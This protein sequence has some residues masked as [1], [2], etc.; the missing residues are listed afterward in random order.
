[1]CGVWAM[2]FLCH[3]LHCSFK[4]TSYRCI[5]F[6]LGPASWLW[7]YLRRSGMGGFF[8][9][10]SGGIDSS[11]TAAIVGSMCH[12]LVEACSKESECVSCLDSTWKLFDTLWYCMYMCVHTVQCPLSCVLCVRMQSVHTTYLVCYICTYVLYVCTYVY[13][14]NAHSTQCTVYVCMYVCAFYSMSYAVCPLTCILQINK[15]SQT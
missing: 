10:L 9:P 6:S 5:Y 12:M 13:I 3:T 15:F 1:M 2:Y 11:S 8:L 14:H 4:S 7:D